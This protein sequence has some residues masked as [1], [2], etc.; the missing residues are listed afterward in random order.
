MNCS[1]VQWAVWPVP[2]AVAAPRWLLGHSTSNKIKISQ[3]GNQLASATPHFTWSIHSAKVA[4]AARRRGA[5]KIYIPTA[6][7]TATHFL[8]SILH[9]PTRH[10][11]LSCCASIIIR[12]N[13][14]NRSVIDF[15]PLDSAILPV[16]VP[17]PDLLTFRPDR[18][19]H[20]G[21]SL[22]LSR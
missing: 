12:H 16:R 4:Q 11:N 20:L 10:N 22:L 8:P 9:Q 21:L 7:T 15:T 1:E 14:I 17:D 2:V 6:P 5:A 19:S 18:P 13:K 3:K